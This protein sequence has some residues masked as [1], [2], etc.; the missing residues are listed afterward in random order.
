MTTPRPPKNSESETLDPF[1]GSPTLKNI[2]GQGIA[3]N[4][5]MPALSVAMMGMMD[6]L[7]KSVS[8]LANKV[9]RMEAYARHSEPVKVKR[10]PPPSLRQ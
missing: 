1:L 7:A 10:A 6:E 5:G 3:R 2:Q 4:D 9:D 8:A